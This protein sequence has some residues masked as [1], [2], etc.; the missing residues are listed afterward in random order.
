MCVYMSVDN[1]SSNVL[2]YCKLSATLS[3]R[4]IIIGLVVRKRDKWSV[5]FEVIE[6]ES[7]K[8]NTSKPRTLATHD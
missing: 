5:I 2:F 4:A 6:P 3:L 7:G 1:F 8:V